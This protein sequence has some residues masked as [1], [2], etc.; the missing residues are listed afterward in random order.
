MNS[1]GGDDPSQN[2]NKEPEHQGIRFWLNIHLPIKTIIL[3]VGMSS[4]FASGLAL[5]TNVQF[6]AQKQEQIQIQKCYS[7]LRTK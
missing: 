2:L 7:D 1:H 3:V 4:A 6:Q 5:G